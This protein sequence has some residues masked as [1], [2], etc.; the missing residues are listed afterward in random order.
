MSLH[1]VA[2]EPL[3]D[4]LYTN[5]QEVSYEQA[6]ACNKTVRAVFAVV[7]LSTPQSVIFQQVVK[8][9]QLTSFVS[10]ELICRK[11]FPSP[12]SLYL[13]LSVPPLEMALS[14]YL[15]EHAVSSLP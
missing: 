10:Q 9:K 3:T 13:S 4:A 6:S 1:T 12:L 2:Q 5:L 8:L 14:T 11:L 7:E 15:T